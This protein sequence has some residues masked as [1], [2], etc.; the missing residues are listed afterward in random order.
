MELW[1][2]T[3]DVKA[4]DKATQC[5]LL[6]GV[7][8]NPAILSKSLKPAET[9]LE[10]LLNHFSGPLA[11]QVTVK[12]AAK[13]ME[14]GKGLFQFS[15]RIVVKV[16]VTEEGIEAIYHL[17]QAG[18]PV[19][20]TTIFSSIQAWLALK[21]GASYVVPYFSHLGESALD[22]SLSIQKM[23]FNQKKLLIASLTTPEQVALC[24]ERGFSAA[25]LKADLFHKCLAA[26]T[27]TLDHLGRFEKAW[28]EAP[29]SELL[30]H[31]Q[32]LS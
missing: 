27:Q 9:I 22:V 30:A 25:T 7:T 17:S 8:T 4:I 10:E 3:I 32:W 11:V 24:A 15:S 29:P 14:Q 1:L 18:I 19:M 20:A 23:L 5:G 31:P 26:P 12:E 16:P 6:Y 28:Q 2:D 21:A 13:M